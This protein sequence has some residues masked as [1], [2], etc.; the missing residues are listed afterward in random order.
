MNPSELNALPSPRFWRRVSCN[1]YEQ[2]ILL[3]VLALT[4]LVPNLIIGIV[5]GMAIPS[6]LTFFYLYGVLAL[7]FT[8]YWRRN[9]Q[10]LAMQTWR[11]QLITEDGYRP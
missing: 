5:F 7:Y 3:G 11:I 10:T 6:W 8:W 9:G 2:L 1:L 4:Y